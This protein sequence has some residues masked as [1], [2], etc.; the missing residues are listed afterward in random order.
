MVLWWY[1]ICDLN[2]LSTLSVNVILHDDDDDAVDDDDD[3]A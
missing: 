1:L 3:H 2:I